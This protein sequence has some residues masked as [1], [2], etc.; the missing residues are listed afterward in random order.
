MK[1]LARPV[2]MLSIVLSA[3]SLSQAQVV[4]TQSDGF[5]IAWDGNDGD[6]F[7]PESPAPVPANLAI[8]PDATAF[9]SSDLG[10]LLPAPFHVALNLND[11]LYGNANSWIGGN[12]PTPSA[13]VRL[14]G[15][16]NITSFAFGRDNGNGAFDDSTP[17][18]DACNGQCDD[19]S[20][21]I[22]TVQITRVAFP[23]P[24]TEDTGDA[25]TGWQTIGTLE[26]IASE[27][28]VPGEGFTAHLRHEYEIAA[29]AAPIQATGFRLLVPRTGLDGGTAIDEIELY[30]QLVVNPDKDGD[31]F[32]DTIEIE[33]GFNPDSPTSTPESL[34]NLRTSVEFSFYAA[35]NKLY[36]I[37]QST[38]LQEWT[39][40]EE[41][42]TG[43]GDEITRLYSITGQPAQHYR[44]V[45]QEP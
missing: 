26:Y 28:A 20:L 39:T 34:V 1:A 15:L 3:S 7:N 44:A 25:A 24:T 12:A 31:G 36:R 40:V 33:L 17:G 35:K 41:D 13:A 10:P 8:A 16:S 22:Y 37:E 6:G 23:D 19:R 4:V 9:T 29:G 27:D 30:G 14:L 45:R 32:D 38:D 43:R 18:T 2:A 42:I 21:G 11:G 5:A